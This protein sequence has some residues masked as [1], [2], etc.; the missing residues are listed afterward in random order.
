MGIRPASTAMLRRLVS[1]EEVGKARWNELVARS[2]RPSVFQTFDWHT[3][4][5]ETFKDPSWELLLIAATAGDSLVGL[6][7]LYLRPLTLEGRGGREIRFIGEGHG[8]YLTLILDRDREGLVEL[9]VEEILRHAKGATRAV[10]REIPAE[11]ELAHYLR[12]RSSQITSRIG[13]VGE[14]ICPRLCLADNDHRLNVILKKEGSKTRAAKLYK[15]LGKLG[16]I[17]VEHYKDAGQILP[18]IGDFFQQHIV[19]WSVTQYPSLFLNPRNCSFYERFIVDLAP[20]GL[21]LLSALRLNDRP[22]AFHLG[23]ASFGDFLYY[24]PTFDLSFA[25]LSPGEVLLRELIEMCASQGFEY[26]DFTR[27]DEAYK[28]RFSSEYHTNLSFMVHR[29]VIGGMVSRTGRATKEIIKNRLF[30]FGLGL[31]AP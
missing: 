2:E 10:L 5:W 30:N 8:D 22:V 9:F 12:A 6:A 17:T 7:P 19:R 27:G 4:W 25:K 15:Q 13:L 28:R 24:K 3:S 11:T 23:L 18:L 16:E 14:M 31:D 20:D 21:V 29:S 1:F 26:F